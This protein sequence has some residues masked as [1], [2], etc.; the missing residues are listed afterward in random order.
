MNSETNVGTITVLRSTVYKIDPTRFD[1][2][3]AVIDG[4][5]EVLD[6]VVLDVTVEPAKES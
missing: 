2:F 1:P 5:A 6:E 4:T 3:D